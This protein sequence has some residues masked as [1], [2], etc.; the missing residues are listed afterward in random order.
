MSS[1]LKARR[2]PRQ[3][4]LKKV[5][6]SKDSKRP[7]FVISFDPRLPSITAIIKKHWRTMS[8]DPRLSEIFPLPPLVAYKRPPNIKQKIIRAKI[9]SVS[10]RPKRES[11]GMRRCLNCAAC[12]FIK[13]GHTVQATQ[14]NFKVD[15]NVQANCLTTNCI[16]LLG[17]KRCPQQYI[18]ESERSLKE[19]FLE[20]KGYVNNNLLSKATGAHFNLKGHK[21]SDMELTI[22]EKIFNPDPQFRK[23]REKMY[24]NKFNTKHKGINKSSGG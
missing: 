19:R 7:V 21:I 6:K 9:P 11:K 2:I 1:F 8:K 15:I 14:S 5:V 20:H 4:A 13:E 23:Q 17:C 24:I 3:E 16:Y 18:G 22:V 12:P 10:S